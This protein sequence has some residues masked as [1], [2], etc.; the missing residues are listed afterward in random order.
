[1]G[2]G[3]L[4]EQDADTS[5]AAPFPINF[6]FRC[7]LLSYAPRLAALGSCLMTVPTNV[8][9]P[10]PI[11]LFLSSSASLS[12]YQWRKSVVSGVP[13]PS[14]IRPP[15]LGIHDLG[16]SCERPHSEE[17]EE[18]EKNVQRDARCSGV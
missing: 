6:F 15:N 10:H 1:M 4:P 13:E 7:L 18:E 14:V 9:S 17:E 8:L 5:G 12:A 3:S 2:H 16:T 11:S